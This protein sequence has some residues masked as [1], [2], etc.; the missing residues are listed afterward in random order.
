MNRNR[1]KSVLK[2]VPHIL[3]ALLPTAAL[4]HPGHATAGGDAFAAGLL[5][6]LSGAD[7]VSALLLAGGWTAIQGHRSMRLP[8]ALLAA[9]AA[10]FL[11][12][13]HLGAALAEGLIALS[14]VVLGVAVALRLRPPLALALPTLALFGFGHGLA[15]GIESNGGASLFMAGMLA[16]SAA[17]IAFGATVGSMLIRHFRPRPARD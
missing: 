6:P 11:V 1:A 16:A 17:L 15:H 9:M 14:V 3:V 8:A 2:A 10:G 4:A 13:P 5:H 12:G 7:H